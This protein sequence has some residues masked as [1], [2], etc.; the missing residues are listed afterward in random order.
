MPATTRPSQLRASKVYYQKNKERIIAQ[1]MAYYATH[2]PEI[3]RKQKQKYDES[4][5]L[6]DAPIIQMIHDVI[7][8]IAIDN[9]EKI[10]L[11]E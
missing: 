3:L 1:K 11:I 2:K 9:P 7:A 4:K 5:N 6:R 10:K 8:Q